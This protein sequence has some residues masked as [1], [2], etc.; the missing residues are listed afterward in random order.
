MN[1]GEL[2]PGG[3]F[4]AVVATGKT[5]GWAFDATSPPTAYQRSGST[6][7]RVAFPGQRFETVVAGPW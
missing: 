7:K 2:V 5:T 6:W 3:N 1:S 4:T